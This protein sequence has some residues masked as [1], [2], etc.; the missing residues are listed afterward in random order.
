MNTPQFFSSSSVLCYFL[1][2]LPSLFFFYSS[3]SLYLF[4]LF[5]RALFVFPWLFFLFSSFPPSVAFPVYILSFC[6]VPLSF[7]LVLFFCLLPLVNFL[8]FPRFI[9]FNFHLFFFVPSCHSFFPSVTLYIFI[10]IFAS[11]LL[12]SVFLFHLRLSRSSVMWIHTH[13]SNKKICLSRGVF[14]LR[15]GR[16]GVNCSIITAPL[17]LLGTVSRILLTPCSEEGQYTTQF[18]YKWRFSQ[19]FDMTAQIIY[20]L[21]THVFTTNVCSIFTIHLP[22]QRYRDVGH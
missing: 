14:P 21:S 10:S 19:L 13:I 15:V 4:S 1:C 16:I 20:L 7:F 2:F 12:L 18:I 8:L 6:L 11:L 9:F 22:Q 17:Q 3:P 5:R